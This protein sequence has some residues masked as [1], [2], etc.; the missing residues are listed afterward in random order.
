M[1]TSADV[2]RAHFRAFTSGLDDVAAFWAATIEWRAVAGAADDVG[3]IRGPGALRRYY[4]DWIDTLAELRAEVGEII[5]DDGDR[6][7]AVI[8]HSGR[9]RASGVPV[10]GRYFVACLIRDGRLVAG[11][12]FNSREEARDAEVPEPSGPDQG[13]SNAELLR[14]LFDRFNETGEL[15][16]ARVAREVELHPRPDVPDGRV[17]RGSKG[18]RDFFAE[19][20]QAFNPIRWEAKEMISEGR[21]VVVRCHVTAYGASSGT[22]IEMDEA[23]LWTFRDGLIVRVQGFPTVEDAHAKLRELDA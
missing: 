10:H 7:A 18:V 12:E 13:A 16:F 1:T 11:R 21:H 22:P 20:A 14:E 9:G 6:V 23:Q 5:R 19:T 15:D 2:L 4:Q 3:L 17:W 8:D